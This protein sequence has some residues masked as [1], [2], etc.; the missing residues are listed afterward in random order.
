LSGPALSRARE[1][2]T[3][4]RITFSVSD[5][6]NELLA[7]NEANRDSWDPLMPQFH[8]RY[9]DASK[10]SA[11]W[12]KGTDSSGRIVAARGYRRFDLPA[13]SS[14]H[15]SLVDLSLFYDNPAQ[16]LPG[17]RIE[18]SAAMPHQ[19]SGSFALSGAL[20]V[21]PGSRRLGLPA[22]MKPIG[23][24]VTHDLWDV[25]LLVALIEDVRNNT[26]RSDNC[27]SGICWKGS[28]VAPQ[29]DFTLVW[30]SREVM[31]KSVYHF[32]GDLRAA[33]QR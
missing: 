18:S 19:I 2:V 22:A 9:F 25:P 12:V 3:D 20:W 26:T 6:F 21:H 10:A 28:Y 23:R 29:C 15:D 31:A 11:F 13:G 16:A 17:E 27:E 4:L 14:L 8:P 33:S 5:D 32:I 1:L 30:W 7:A 24:A